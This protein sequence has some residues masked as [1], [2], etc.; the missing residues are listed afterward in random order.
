MSD[1]PIPGSYESYKKAVLERQ[2][3]AQERAAKYA[4]EG[5]QAE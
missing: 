5:L 2:V 4:R 1:W 3:A